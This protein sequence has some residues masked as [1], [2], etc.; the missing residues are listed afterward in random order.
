VF[1]PPPP[2]PEL[3]LGGEVVV[4]VAKIV[5]TAA[6]ARLLS[7]EA[8]EDFPAEFFAVTVTANC[9]VESGV[10]RVNSKTLLVVTGWPTFSH[11][12]PVPD[13]FN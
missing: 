9:V 10:V 7:T 13:F 12:P 4:G 6:V 2:F 5:A 8:S 1:V 3:G 11:A